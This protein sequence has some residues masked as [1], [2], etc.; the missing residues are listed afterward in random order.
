[1]AGKLFGERETCGLLAC[2]ERAN[3]RMLEGGH[4]SR[5]RA[6]D[7]RTSFIKG[8]LMQNGARHPGGK[9]LF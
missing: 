1:M 9:M 2:S 5:S 7:G 3:P 8:A 4:C 6:Q